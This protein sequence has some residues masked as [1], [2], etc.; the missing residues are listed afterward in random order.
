MRSAVKIA[1]VVLLGLM[2]AGIH[3]APLSADPPP[4]PVAACPGCTRAC[5]A[6]TREAPAPQPATPVRAS[7][8]SSLFV[9][10]LIRSLAILPNTRQAIST[11][12]SSSPLKAT[13]VPL[14]MR[15]CAYLI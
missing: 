11:P 15:N 5:C 13:A 10:V 2:L 14:Y 3:G 6:A 7:N 9:A 1:F 8:P 4:S 12:F